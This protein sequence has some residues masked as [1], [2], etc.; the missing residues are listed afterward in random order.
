MHP[1]A[2]RIL[3]WIA[4]LVALLAMGLGVWLAKPPLAPPG[5]AKQASASAPA[6]SLPPLT[7]L[8]RAAC[9]GCHAEQDR[10]WQGSHHD[11]AMQAANDATV[12]GDFGDAEFR[13]DGVISR[14]FRQDGRYVVRTDGPD[15]QLADFEIK[16][17]FGITT[18]QQY[19]VELPGGRLQ[20]LSIAWDSRSKEQGGQRWFHLYPKEKI[21]PTDELHWTKSSQNWNI[22][23]AECHS[24]HL[25]KDY[26][27]ASRTYRTTWSEID[28]AC[29]ACH[30]P[31]SQHVAWA[32][33][34]PG[35]EQVD[36][37]TK[38]LAV[39]LDERKGIQW[40]IDPPSG[41]ARRSAPRSSEKEIQICA[42][43][44]ARR[45]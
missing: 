16:Y 32:E 2:Q 6:P 30:G 42:R 13:K 10:L 9:A 21:D 33:R 44:H 45:A 36:P 1:Q 5:P 24:T 8:G 15:G 4:V 20:A 17:T 14:F 22:M 26:D 28:V 3:I 27:P 29:E 37:Q 11:L 19:L 34:K 38:G 18:L 25:Q 40:T 31:G 35:T 41:N 12:L 39:L 23:C 43:C 7:Y